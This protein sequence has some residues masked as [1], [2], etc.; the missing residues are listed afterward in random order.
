[1]NKSELIDFYHTVRKTTERLCQPLCTEDHVIQSMPDVSP[2]K[3]HLGHTTWFFEQVILGR[4]LAEYR[5]FHELYAFLFNS[6]YQSFGDRVR[7]EVR[8]TLSRP[9]V[10]EIRTYRSA[11]DDQM[12]TFLEKADQE[13]FQQ[14]SPLVELGLHHEQQ[15]QELLVTD[16]KH[17]LGSNPLRP[18]YR[19]AERNGAAEGA[20][21]PARFVPVAGGVFEIGAG[22]EGFAWDNERP[23]HRVMLGD[24]L[25]MNRPVSC[26]EY[27]E[28]MQDGGYQNPL[29][30]LSDG[31]DAVCSERWQAPLYW[32]HVEGNWRI[33]TLSGTRTVAPD[34]PVCHVSFYEAAAFA[35]WAGK[36]L[37]SEF[38]WEVAAGKAGSQPRGSLLEDATWHPVPSR[39]GSA[40]A[41]FHQLLGGVWEW[42]NSSYLPYPGYQQERGPLGEYNGKFMIN[43][44]VLR[45]GSCATPR[46]HIR[47]TYRNFFQCDK[48]WQF[49]GI[50]LASD[51]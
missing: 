7:R 24:F 42:T 49:S 35:R 17:I 5:P 10:Q 50:R 44:M 23:R 1:M 33:F 6:Y 15:H 11:V 9:T 8:G 2:P 47:P 20:S 27:L 12:H 36:R 51:P 48:R 3:W 26:R 18:A 37:P 43:Q 28:F 14:V 32:E 31:W 30:W 39:P 46:S 19:V 40:D 25:L 38:E 21:G 34:E 45:G 41:A 29:L 13:S 22:P 16:I 4:F